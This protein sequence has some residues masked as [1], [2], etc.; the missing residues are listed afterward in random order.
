MKQRHSV[1]TGFALTG[2][3]AAG[4]I[5]EE[6]K[7]ARYESHEPNNIIILVINKHSVITGRG[8]LTSVIATGFLGFITVI[9]FLFCTPD[10]D[11][12]FSLNAPQPFVQIYSL[13]LGKRGSIIM[14]AIAVIGLTLVCPISG[15]RTKLF[16]IS[17][18]FTEYQR[19]HCCRFQAYICSGS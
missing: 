17:W 3:D 2:F 6:T 16:M 18:V 15:Y 19:C 10:L 11:M 13:A 5:A 7:N 4:D 1:F 12:A 14:T 9:L 8:I